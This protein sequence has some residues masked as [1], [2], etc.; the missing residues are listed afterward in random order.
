M[1]HTR[2]IASQY[3]RVESKKNILPV[4]VAWRAEPTTLYTVAST[5][6]RA[7]PDPLPMPGWW[8]VGDGERPTDCIDIDR[9]LTSPGIQLSIET[10]SQAQRW[11]MPGDPNRWISAHGLL[12]D[13]SYHHR[14]RLVER[15]APALA[16]VEILSSSSS[17]KAP[18]LTPFPGWITLVLPTLFRCLNPSVPYRLPASSPLPYF[19]GSAYRPDGPNYSSQSR[20]RR[21]KAG[22]ASMQLCSLVRTPNMLYRLPPTK[23]YTKSRTT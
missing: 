13:R 7:I 8:V 20:N 3:T 10:C 21:F 22:V 11:E 17:G 14:V 4:I 23:S 9:T 1:I 15:R 12:E 6:R 16:L 5:S 2:S 19:L 18:W